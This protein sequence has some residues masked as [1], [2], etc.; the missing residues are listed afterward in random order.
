MRAYRSARSFFVGL[1]LGDIVIQ[2]FWTLTSRM[3]N[4]PVYQFLS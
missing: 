4:V 3:L 1:I 2:A